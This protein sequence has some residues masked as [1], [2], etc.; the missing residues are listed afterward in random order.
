MPI[1]FSE[2]SINALKEALTLAGLLNAEVFLLHVMEYVKTEISFSSEAQQIPTSNSDFSISILKKMEELKGRIGKEFNIVPEVFITDGDIEKQ[3]NIFSEKENID[4]IVMGTHGVSGYKEFF[5]GSNAQRVVIFSKVP[6]LTLQSRVTNYEFK[7]ILIPIDNSTFSREK[8]DITL[9]I[10]K[11]FGAKIHLIGLTNS[12]EIEEINKFKIKLEAIE[13]SITSCKLPYQSL[14]VRGDNL[15]EAAI[16]YAN[17][18]NCDLITINSG[19]ESNIGGII[20]GAFV[21]HIVNHATI[22][23]LSFKY[24]HGHFTFL[25]PGFGVS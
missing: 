9:I 18:N 13:N 12:E 5:L 19:H 21:Q 24:R 25:A 14:I 23:V 20:L 1:D 8:V 7:N 22:P 4:L 10:A 3:I 17:E 2:T 16:H 11:L 15:A 6:V